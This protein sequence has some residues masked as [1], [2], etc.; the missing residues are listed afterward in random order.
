VAIFR[1]SKRPARSVAA[2][3]FR[4]S[5]RLHLSFRSRLRFRKERTV[6]YDA[7]KKNLADSGP[8]PTRT[9]PR[10]FE[11]SAG[12][13]ASA[14][15]IEEFCFSFRPS[16]PL[17]RYHYSFY[18]LRYVSFSL[19]PRFAFGDVPPRGGPGGEHDRG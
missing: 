14:E 10:F 2:N 7:P 8:L 9:A 18:G 15:G 13:V 19:T 4:C 1:T 12:P 5:Q 11:G 3:Y 16:E 6:A 17:I